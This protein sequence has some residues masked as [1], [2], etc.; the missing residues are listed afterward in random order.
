MARTFNRQPYVVNTPTNSE[1]KN[2]YFNTLNWKGKVDDKNFATVDQETFADC[3]NVYVDE[4]NLLK[5]R[6]V[7]KHTAKRSTSYAGGRLIRV[8]DLGDIVCYVFENTEIASGLNLEF[9]FKNTLIY[10]KFEEGPC[11]ITRVENSIY[12]FSEHIVELK[13][14]YDGDNVRLESNFDTIYVPVTSVITNGVKS[15]LDPLNELTT[16]YKE[17]YIYDPD[18]YS[19]YSPL[20]GKLVTV[21]IDEKSYDMNFNGYSPRLLLSK[22]TS[23]NANFIADDTILGKYYN[24][25][26]LIDFSS[27][28]TFVRSSFTYNPELHWTNEYSPDGKLY[29]SLPF[30]QG[31]TSPAKISEDGAYV[32]AYSSDGLYIISVLDTEDRDY[33]EDWKN[34]LEHYGLENSSQLF[35]PTGTRNIFNSVSAKTCN[36]FVCAIAS[37]QF[38]D[39]DVVK[40]EGV[41][42]VRCLDGNISINNVLDYVSDYPVNECTQIS[43]NAFNVAL[44]MYIGDDDANSTIYEIHFFTRGDSRLVCWYNIKLG[45]FV[46]FRLLKSDTLQ[47]INNLSG[48]MVA[49]LITYRI[50]YNFLNG[51]INNVFVKLRRHLSDFSTAY[52]SPTGD[53]LTDAYAYVNSVETELPLK[54]TPLLFTSEHTYVIDENNIVYSNKGIRVITVTHDGRD[55]IF[56]V[57]FS[58]ELD[59]N[60]F[61]DNDKLYISKYPTEG[62]FKWYFPNTYTETLPSPAVNALP[63]S[64]TELVVNCLSDTII[65]SKTDNGFTYYKSKVP[66][67]PSK[68]SDIIYDFTGKY[69]ITPSSRGI[70]LLSYQDFVASTEQ[71]ATYITDSIQSTYDVFNNSGI[72]LAKFKFYVFC[73]K[74]NSNE[75]LV[76]DV[77]TNSWWPWKLP[78]DIIQLYV[79]DDRLHLLSDEEYEFVTTFDDYY[80]ELANEIVPVNWYVKS[81]R[82]HLNA[83][84]YLKH[85]SNITLSAVSDNDIGKLDTLSMDMIITNYRK[86]RNE[87][88]A[89]SFEFDIDSVRIYVKKLNYFKVNEFQYLLK[90]NDNFIRFP[91]CLSNITIKYRIAGQVK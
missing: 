72:K 5:S 87:L 10:D 32:F 22:Y 77:R 7:A 56:N 50:A 20:Y 54:G 3:S 35:E 37:K 30:L 74:K 12:I 44:G 26:P 14:L 38:T 68:G 16:K 89:Q 4:C 2:Y 36:N 63:L 48:N 43:I 65:V 15:N 41:R 60:Y 82:L 18:V 52:I 91:L 42:I 24:G 66:L 67:Q 58:V 11:H 25:K 73:Y 33:F 6:P 1:A 8:I 71:T 51:L 78:H 53:V 13:I 70:A 23:M 28:G 62:E 29:I 31:Q 64:A 69:V 39:V 17:R 75:I 90:S 34:V 80:D 61:F 79:I 57:D 85:I 86:Q 88:D 9:F 40:Y 81:Q 45:D 27:N 19:N 83:N 46:S 47:V 55:T 59:E 49:R 84:N 76:F 21:D